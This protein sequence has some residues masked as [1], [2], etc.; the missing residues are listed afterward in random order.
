MHAAFDLR[1]IAAILSVAFTFLA[2]LP[3]FLAT[4]SH[5]VRP[6]FVTWFLWALTSG[7]GAAAQYA[8]GASLS[9][10]VVLANAAASA[11][12]A[13]LALRHGIKKYSMLDTVCLALA[14]VTVA[15]WFLSDSAILALSLSIATDLLAALPT[16][17]KAYRRPSSEKSWTYFSF[18]LAALL[19]VAS[20]DILDLPNL[21]YPIYFFALY[22]V[23]GV[24]A[25]RHTKRRSRHA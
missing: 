19:G 9:L 12:I 10:W 21:A 22:A 23:I 16:L 6:D 15:L 11:A 2:L 14:F 1:A 5:K 4:L 8:S 25:A 20:S 18:A 13:L 24:L 17:H 3:Y 7:V